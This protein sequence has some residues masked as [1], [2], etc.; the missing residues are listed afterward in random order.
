MRTRATTA[1]L[2]V[3]VDFMKTIAIFV[4]DALAATLLDGEVCVVL[5]GQAAVDTTRLGGI[6]ILHRRLMLTRC[7][8]II[9]RC[10]R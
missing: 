8:G 7:Q 5:F 2:R 1:F 3:V 9:S 6:M 10:T 4:A